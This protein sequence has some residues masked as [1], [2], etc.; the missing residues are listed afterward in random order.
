MVLILI[1]ILAV[2]EAVGED[3]AEE[4]RDGGDVDGDVVDGHVHFVGENNSTFLHSGNILSAG[5][6]F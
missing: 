5:C 2:D 6:F 1:L 4:Q 3:A